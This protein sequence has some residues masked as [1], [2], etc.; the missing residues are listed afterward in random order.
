MVSDF[1]LLLWNIKQ[2]F[3]RYKNRHR[4]DGKLGISEYEKRRIF[5]LERFSSGSTILFEQPFLF[6]CNISFLHS[7]EEIFEEEVYRF[8][9]ENKTPLII[10]CGANIGLSVLYFRRLFP[11]AKI[12]AFEP[13]EGI[14]KILQKNMGLIP[15]SNLIEFRLLY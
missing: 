14:F 13:D 7:L 12:I 9:T 10:D 15:Q 4:I 1:R 11:N 5:S 8:Q 2:Q 6:S 3:Y